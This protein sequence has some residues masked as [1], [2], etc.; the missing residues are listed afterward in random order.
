[1]HGVVEKD[2][3]NRKVRKAGAKFTKLKQYISAL[4]DLS[5]NP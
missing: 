5:V 3:Y 2:L 1:M 4:C